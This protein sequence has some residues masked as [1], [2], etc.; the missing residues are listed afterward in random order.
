MNVRQVLAEKPR[1]TT[2]IT[3]AVILVVLG[4][5]VYTNM[6]G[7]VGGGPGPVP[8][9]SFFTVDDGKTWFAADA[10]NIPPFEH[11]GRQAVLARVYRC[12]G[13]TFV[14]HMERFTPQ[15]K[16]RLE[17]ALARSAGGA[18]VFLADMGGIEVKAPGSGEWISASH[19]SAAK[20]IAPK[21]PGGDVEIVMP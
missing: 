8:N 14:N 21:C 2:A 19:P 4:Y 20:V 16:K 6:R 18:D 13:K 5:I 15:A 3:V 12:D 17:E 10:N 9:Q 1:I 7:G 11:N